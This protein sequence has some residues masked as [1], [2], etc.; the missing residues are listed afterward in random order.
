MA[1]NELHIG[2]TMFKLFSDDGLNS[3][4]QGLEIPAAVNCSQ[5]DRANLRTLVNL[6]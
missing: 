3:S 6:L 4:I 5:I 2:S 1:F